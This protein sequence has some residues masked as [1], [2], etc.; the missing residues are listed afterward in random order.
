MTALLTLANS[1]AGGAAAG[2]ILAGGILCW[3][4]MVGIGL[5]YLVFT[6]LMVI[7]AAQRPSLND[8]S[9]R[10]VWILVI[11]FAPLGPVIYYFA[12]RK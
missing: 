11:I 3:L 7:D 12:G 1:A 2:G 8:G 9:M 5:A 10:I 4:I 6:I